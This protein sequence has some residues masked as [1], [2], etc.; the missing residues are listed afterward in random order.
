MR[1]RLWLR[2]SVDMQVRHAL[3]ILALDHDIFTDTTG[4][5]VFYFHDRRHTTD[6]AAEALLEG[7][8]DAALGRPGPRIRSDLQQR[9]AARAA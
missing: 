3:Q 9:L 4:G 6:Q 8:P 7:G 2:M 1:Q 5:I